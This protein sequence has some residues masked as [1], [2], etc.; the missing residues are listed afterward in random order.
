LTFR[1]ATLA[2]ALTIAS[3][4]AASAAQSLYTTTRGPACKDGSKAHFSVWRCPGPAGYAAEYS[5]EGNL[6]AIAL[7]IPGPTSR[8]AATSLVWRGGGRVFGHLL[9]WRIDREN[10][11]AAILR[12]WRLDASSAGGSE[13]QEEL[14]LL[15]LRPEGSCRVVTVPARRPNANEVAR[16]LS[17]QVG[18]M[19]CLGDD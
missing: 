7:W 18:S 12:I 14:V 19:P 16:A 13:P 1:I 11:V 15:K 17:S 8:R 3:M 10:P 6:A 2:F 4:V 9:E 5:D